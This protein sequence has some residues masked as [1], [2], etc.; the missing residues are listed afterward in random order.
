M[1]GTADCDDAGAAGKTLP[2]AHC[3]DFLV[4]FGLQCGHFPEPGKS[5]YIC[6][7]EDED[8]AR[9]VFECFSGSG[10]SGANSRG[11]GQCGGDGHLSYL[12]SSMIVI[13]IV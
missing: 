2:N 10:D 8:T 7:A 3:L 9:Q 13:T 12:L 5:H 11:G 6:K 1:R 4:K